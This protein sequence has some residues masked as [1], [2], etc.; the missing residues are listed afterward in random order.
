MFWRVDSSQGVIFE[1]RLSAAE[2]DI[3]IA[4][5]KSRLSTEKSVC[6]G[7]FLKYDHVG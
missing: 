3:V 2:M 5:Q 6:K 1:R 4:E 7:G